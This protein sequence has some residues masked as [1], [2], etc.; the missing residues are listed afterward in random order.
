V[1]SLNVREML[2]RS[3]M[4]T[5]VYSQPEAY[6]FCHDSLLAPRLI[7][8]DISSRLV[9]VDLHAL[10]LCALDLCAGCGVM[11]FELLEAL[12]KEMK[13]QGGVADR[14]S[15]FDFLEIENE[16]EVHFEANRTITGAAHAR[17]ILANYSTLQN[18][19]YSKTYDLIIAN[20]PYFFNNEGCLSKNSI[21]NRARFFLD[22]DLR[23]LLRGVRNALKVGGY[24]YIL[25]KSGKKHG[26]DALTSARLDLFDCEF[27]CLA[28]VR[29][30]DLVRIE[31]LEA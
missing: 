15:R 24:A 9:E 10:D 13:E 25:M 20:P 2:P 5:H 26:R 29:G 7:A 31:R 3:P 28:D 12:K 22:S 8:A 23:T 17:W 1:K 27:K 11:G 18:E 6:H 19:E 4:I 30:T 14:I 21:N 16:F